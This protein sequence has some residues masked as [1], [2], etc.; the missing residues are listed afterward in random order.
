VTGTDTFAASAYTYT[1]E[2]MSAGVSDVVTMVPFDLTYVRYEKGDLVGLLLAGKFVI[3]TRH[4][5]GIRR[6]CIIYWYLTLFLMS[7]LVYCSLCQL[8]LLLRYSLWLCTL[9]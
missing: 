4:R 9:Q 7:V 2:K 6:D 8:S 3:I 5:R 1:I